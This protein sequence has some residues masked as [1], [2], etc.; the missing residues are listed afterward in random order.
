MKNLLTSLDDLYLVV[1]FPPFRLKTDLFHTAAKSQNMILVLRRYV[2][3]VSV[4]MWKRVFRT[5][6][7]V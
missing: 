5:L 6:V 2:L 7:S 3:E 1:I 4:M